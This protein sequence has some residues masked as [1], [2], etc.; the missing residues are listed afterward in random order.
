MVSIKEKFRS[1]SSYMGQPSEP[2]HP[3]TLRK[4]LSLGDLLSLTRHSNT[5]TIMANAPTEPS[6]PEHNKPS[7]VD[8]LEHISQILCRDAHRSSSQPF[9][10]LPRDANKLEGIMNYH[11]GQLDRLRLELDLQNETIERLSR[12]LTP[13]DLEHTAQKLLA[14]VRVARNSR[15]LLAPFMGFHLREIKRIIE[16]RWKM[17][18]KDELPTL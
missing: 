8:F 16:L 6:A 15:N 18:G 10:E 12:T 7:I 9:D 2:Q 13:E 11:L 17:S 5:A 1:E 14:R 3:S 4:R